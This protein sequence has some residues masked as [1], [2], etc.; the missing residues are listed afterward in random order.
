MRI[1]FISEKD[2][3]AAEAG[4]TIGVRQGLSGCETRVV[5]IDDNQVAIQF[6]SYKDLEIL[7]Q[8]KYIIGGGSALEKVKIDPDVIPWKKG[9]GLCLEAGGG[10]FF[11]KVR[12]DDWV[13]QQALESGYLPPRVW[14]G[15]KEVGDIHPLVRRIEFNGDYDS[16]SWDD[17]H[18]HVEAERRPWF[19]E[20]EDDKT[21]RGDSLGDL[22]AL[23]KGLYRLCFY[24]TDDQGQYRW[25]GFDV[26]GREEYRYWAK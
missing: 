22:K 11:I 8:A 12:P 21:F 13:A 23:P 14:R 3:C 16:A 2:F 4:T 17:T 19:A 20:T 24:G 5:K 18:Y 7:E 15:Y 6:L 25:V 9:F 26:H 1:K 10:W